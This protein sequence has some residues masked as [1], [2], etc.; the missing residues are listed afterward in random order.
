MCT[1]WPCLLPCHW[2][3]DKQFNLICVVWLKSPA[4][5]IRLLCFPQYELKR[6]REV[7]RNCGH[8]ATGREP[9]WVRA[10]TCANEFKLCGREAEWVEEASQER[11]DNRAREKQKQRW[12]E[13]DAFGM[14]FPTLFRSCEICTSSLLPMHCESTHHIFFNNG[15]TS[16]LSWL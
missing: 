3:Q 16:Y 13:L 1:K 9:W 7:A 10:G 15:T 4:V 6:Q 14:H 5:P 8:R 12:E 11:E 2:W